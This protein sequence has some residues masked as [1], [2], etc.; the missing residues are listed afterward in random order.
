MMR[1]M[2]SCQF[3]RGPEVGQFERELAEYLQCGHVVSCGNGTDALRLACMALGIGLGD[4]VIT[5]AYSFIAAAEAVA[6]CGATPVF[7][8]ID[9]QTFNIDPEA[10]EPL[11]TQHTRAI[12]P[13]HLFGRPCDMQKIMDIA[14]RHDLYVIEDMAQAMG[15]WTIV[16]GK[17]Q[18]LGAIGAIGCTSFFPSKNL[19]CMGDGGAL[20]IGDDAF[21]DKARMLANHGS[22]EKYHNECIGINSRLDT[23][24]AAVLSVKLHH[25]GEFTRR[26]REAAAEYNE[27]LSGID[28]IVLPEITEGHVFHQYTLRIKNN[29]RD[30]LRS[31]LSERGI[32]TMIYF[33]LSLNCQ[34]AFSAMHPARCPESERASQETLS[35]PIHSEITGDTVAT[36][37]KAIREWSLTN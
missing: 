12:A 31:Y 26:R 28:G 27:L 29:R 14:H 8:D 20:M 21:A 5:S 23:L 2:E 6:A 24:Q 11:I 35:L 17:R 15:A 33:P 4:E 22:H 34:Q 10:I 18:M 13:V 19:S 37:A 7:A 16:D 9:P 36:V 30:A 25:M 32:A 1:V 3:V